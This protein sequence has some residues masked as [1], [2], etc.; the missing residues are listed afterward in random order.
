MPT[1][2]K[3]RHRTP[4]I[5]WLRAAVLGA[6]DGILSTSSLVLGV[7]AAQ[8]RH[9]SSLA[10]PGHCPG[11][12]GRPDP[13]CGW[14]FT[15]VPPASRGTGRSRRWHKSDVGRNTRHL[16]GCA[17]HGDHVRRR[18]VVRNSCVSAVGPHSSAK[19]ANEWG[20]SPLAIAVQPM[21]FSS[22]RA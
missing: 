14:D 5:G 17:R 13:S 9:R 3:E 15:T 16:L 7:A 6:N 21:S 19:V 8:L 22:N 20:I 18:M 4:R 11:S 10:S 2:K 1:G 12:G